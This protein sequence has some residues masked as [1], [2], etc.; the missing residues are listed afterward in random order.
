LAAK[1]E[2]FTGRSDYGPF[3]EEGI[4]IPAG[5]LFTGAEVVKTVQDQKDA[6]GV[7]NVAYD[8]CYHQACDDINN[9][10]TEALQQ[11]GDAAAYVLERLIVQSDVR[12]YLE[13]LGQD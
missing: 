6:G 11:M 4:D 5:G 7:A 3:I 12:G 2:D 10:N 8:P 9:I 1:L 13:N